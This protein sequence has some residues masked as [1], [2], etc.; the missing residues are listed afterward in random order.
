[1]SG[2]W[3]PPANTRVEHGSE[4]RRAWDDAA[5]EGTTLISVDL[6]KI[7]VNRWGRWS[8]VQQETAH[9]SGFPYFSLHPPLTLSS[10]LFFQINSWLS[11]NLPYWQCD[12]WQKQ[13]GKKSVTQFKWALEGTWAFSL[14]WIIMGLASA[15]PGM[16]RWRVAKPLLKGNPDNS[17]V[18]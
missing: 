9:L 8:E 5:C 10:L 4:T 3:H 13:G 2:R 11:W 15:G 6:I 14:Q 12:R 17:Y 1:M 18:K 7:G 16:L